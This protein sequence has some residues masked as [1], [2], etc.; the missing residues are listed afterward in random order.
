[1]DLKKFIISSNK[2]YGIFVKIPQ[3]K[4]G[5][6]TIAAQNIYLVTQTKLNAMLAYRVVV[7]LSIF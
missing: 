4:T 1:M 5:K 6:N 2:F 3:I 7:F